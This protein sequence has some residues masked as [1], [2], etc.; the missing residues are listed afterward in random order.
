[1][2]NPNMDQSAYLWALKIAEKFSKMT[3]RDGRPR[4][5]GDLWISRSSQVGHYDHDEETV[6]YHLH[7]TSRRHRSLICVALTMKMRS[8]RY[9]RRLP[10]FPTDQSGMITLKKTIFHKKMP[11]ASKI[12]QT[13]W[14]VTGVMYDQSEIIEWWRDKIRTKQA[15]SKNLDGCDEKILQKL[16]FL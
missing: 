11:Q 6:V 13:E 15:R 10:I 5:E 14:S 3:M 4:L 7:F 2:D 16:K 1:M 12:F 8:P 9:M